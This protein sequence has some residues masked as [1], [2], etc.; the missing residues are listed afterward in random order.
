MENC[1]NLFIL[2]GIDRLSFAVYNLLDTKLIFLSEYDIIQRFNILS[3]IDEALK[4]DNFLTLKFKKVVVLYSNRVFELIPDHLFDEKFQNIFLK[5]KYSIKTDIVLSDKI[6]NPALRVIYSVN[7]SLYE[8]FF[9]KF[10]D[11]NFKSVSSVLLENYAA[12]SDVDNVFTHWS[13]RFF[14]LTIYRKEKLLIHR[15]YNFDNASDALYILLLAF[16]QFSLPTD[17]QTLIIS[18]NLIEDSEIFRL[19][20]VY[21]GSIYFMENTAFIHFEDDNT[22]IESHVYHTFY[23]A[24]LCEL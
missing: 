17:S 23:A 7:E 14:Y 22:E 1:Y 3:E 6:N 16:K 21:F 5:N 10:T 20:K 24:S 15:A 8:F 11:V 13:D 2:I 18:G 9:K 4:S 12:K 19:L